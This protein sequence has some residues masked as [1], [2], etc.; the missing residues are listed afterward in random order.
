MSRAAVAPAS[1]VTSVSL[2]DV[3]EYMTGT[4]FI[5]TSGKV[6]VVRGY[7]TSKVPLS[8][9]SEYHFYRSVEGTG[10]LHALAFDADGNRWFV[11]ADG[12]VSVRLSRSVEAGTG[13]AMPAITRIV[14]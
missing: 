9:G 10:L 1:S 8:G 3:S 11:N 5:V 13:F 12:S 2:D 4:L 14:K 7:P 6:Q